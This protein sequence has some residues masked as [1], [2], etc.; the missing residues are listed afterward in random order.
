MEEAMDL[1]EDIRDLD[2]DMQN[3]GRK[4]DAID[5]GV[6]NR[7]YTLVEIKQEEILQAELD[8]KRK[9]REELLLALET[10]LEDEKKEKELKAELMRRY[11]ES[12]NNDERSEIEQYAEITRQVTSRISERKINNRIEG[13]TSRNST[14]RF[15]KKYSKEDDDLEI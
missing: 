11:Q 7:A 13:I 4:I 15:G 3:I 10:I 2:L 5:N 12:S 9:Q 8:E 6:R 1:L 14:T